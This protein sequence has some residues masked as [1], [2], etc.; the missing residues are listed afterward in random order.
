MKINLDD[1]GKGLALIER[2]AQNPYI[3]GIILG[4]LPH[5]GLTPEQAAQVNANHADYLQRI[6]DA[7][8]R[9]GQ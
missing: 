5:F 4:L 2:G 8:D 7:D 3:R 9:A 6:Q 1:I